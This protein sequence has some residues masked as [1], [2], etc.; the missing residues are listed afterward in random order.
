MKKHLFILCTVVLAACNSKQD[1]SSRHFTVQQLAPGVWAAIHTD[2]TGFA[3]CNAGIVD[4][5][6]KTLVFDCFISPAAAEDLR[7]AAIHF[8][9]RPAD[10][11]VNSH[12]H[13]DHIRGNQV[14]LPGARII[15]TAWTREEIKTEE[16][17]NIAHTK[18]VIG[19]RLR[20]YRQRYDSAAA[21]K[22]AE[23]LM[24]LNYYEAISQSL[25]SLQTV[26]PDSVFNDSLRVKGSRR[27]VLLLECHNAHTGSDAVM[28]L[29]KEGILFLGDMFFIG[30]HPWLAD[31]DP[32]SWK[33]H[34]LRF[35]G[36]ASITQYVPGHGPV[37]G[38]QDMQAMI[39]YLSDLQQLTADAVKN[40]IPDSVFS[41]TPPPP[42]Y[43]TWWYGRFLPGNLSFLYQR[44]SQ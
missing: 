1:F 22:K 14:F 29:E 28:L 32:E 19:D 8:T 30:R 15:S 4:L 20:T 3:I 17:G 36:D 38:K 7:Q 40:G 27:D 25:P 9:G 42:A 31:G 23:A 43:S 41:K 34:L 26:L 24:W 12:Y 37:G 16:P 44:A 10:Y 39:G 33:Q 18:E 5:G 13:D 2:S 21:D 11:V 6:D 35:T